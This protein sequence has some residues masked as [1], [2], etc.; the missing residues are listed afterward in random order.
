MTT[1]MT[2]TT[3]KRWQA[4][5]TCEQYCTVIVRHHTVSYC[6]ANGGLLQY[7]RY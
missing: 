4:P 5:P 7:S 3:M 2:T 1:T 6:T